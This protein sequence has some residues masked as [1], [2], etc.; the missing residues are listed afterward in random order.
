MLII[1][2]SLAKVEITGVL[3]GIIDLCEFSKFADAGS[4]LATQAPG[5]TLSAARLRLN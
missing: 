4:W 2:E 3:T 5:A 1:Y